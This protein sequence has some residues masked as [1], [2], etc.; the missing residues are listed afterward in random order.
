MYIVVGHSVG[1]NLVMDEQLHKEITRGLYW[2]MFSLVG[3]VA[4]CF[5]IFSYC[6]EQ[7]LQVRVTKPIQ[8]LS[9]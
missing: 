2:F 7:R 3:G 9:R 5:V 8:E 1:L 4:I 6:F